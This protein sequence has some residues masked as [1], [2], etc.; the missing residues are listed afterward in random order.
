MIGKET[1]KKPSLR[2]YYG[3]TKRFLD[4]PQYPCGFP[5]GVG[6]KIAEK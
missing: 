4:T 1:T 5:E 3:T 2:K 6:R